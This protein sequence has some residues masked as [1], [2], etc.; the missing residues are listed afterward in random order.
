MHATFHPPSIDNRA[1]L[2]AYNGLKHLYAGT[3]SIWCHRRQI[4]AIVGR[5]GDASHYCHEGRLP[6][7]SQS[8]QVLA[9]RLSLNKD[10]LTVR[11][12]DLVKVGGLGE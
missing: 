11:Q 6:V 12:D 9:L 7:E 5:R 10:I 3:R 1:T 8:L 2:L 4:W